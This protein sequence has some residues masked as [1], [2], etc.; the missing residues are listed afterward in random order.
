VH[1]SLALSRTFGSALTVNIPSREVCMRV[2]LHREGEL[3]KMISL[4]GCCTCPTI[5]PRATPVSPWTSP[6]WSTLDSIKYM[7]FFDVTF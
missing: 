2:A 4:E 5:L 3:E 1:R 6:L 7:M